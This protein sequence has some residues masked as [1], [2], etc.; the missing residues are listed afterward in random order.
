MKSDDLC[1]WTIAMNLLDHVLTFSMFSLFSPTRFLRFVSRTSYIVL[2]RLIIWVFKPSPP[3]HA[4]QHT[5]P[6]GRIAVVGA[7]VSGVSSAAHAIAHGFDVVIYE[8]GD[9][10]AFGLTLIRPLAFSFIRCFTGFIQG[11]FGLARSL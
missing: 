1:L 5:K 7:G 11:Y 3:K 10:V 2:Q 6:L 8:K 4:C 9:R